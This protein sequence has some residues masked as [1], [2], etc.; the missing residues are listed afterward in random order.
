MNKQTKGI[1]EHYDAPAQCLSK[2]TTE[3]RELV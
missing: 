2:E 1:K 3:W